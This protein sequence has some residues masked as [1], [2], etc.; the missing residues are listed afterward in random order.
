MLDQWDFS[1]DMTTYNDIAET[2]LYH[3]SVNFCDAVILAYIFW[4]VAVAISPDQMEN[5]ALQRVQM[6][7]A[8]LI[9]YRVNP[10]NHFF[11]VL[12]T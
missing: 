4:K 3:P 12:E 10:S 5:Q 6:S 8:E 11:F 2:T 9:D 1:V 7:S